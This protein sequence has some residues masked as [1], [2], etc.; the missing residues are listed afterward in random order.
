ME[1]APYFRLDREEAMATWEEVAQV[2]T[3]WR[4]LAKELGMRSTDLIDFLSAFEPDL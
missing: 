2:V 3:S 1:G 4:S